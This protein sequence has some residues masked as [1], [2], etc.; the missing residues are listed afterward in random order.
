MSRPEDKLSLTAWLDVLSAVFP[1]RGTLVVGAGNG[2]G[3]WVQWLRER[4]A[5]PVLLVEGDD[6]QYQHLRRH[7]QPEL[8]WDLRHEIVAAT[9]GPVVFYRASNLAESGLIQPEGLQAL[10]PHLTMTHVQDEVAA[11]TLDS[12]AQGTGL[13]FNWLVLD[14]MPAA[15]LLRGGEAL[16]AQA[17]V[18]LVRAA[19]NELPNL[20][21]EAGRSAAGD[22]LQASGL[23]GVQLWPQR[24]PA[25]AHLLYIRDVARQRDHIRSALDR[26]DSGDR[27]IKE[28]RAEMQRM[29]EE[30]NAAV[31][32]AHH[33]SKQQIEEK[34]KLQEAAVA[35]IVQSSDVKLKAVEK[36]LK[37]SL[38]QEISNSVSQIESYL[39]LQSYLQT[40]KIQPR[41]HG[42]AVSPDFALLVVEILEH[43]EFDAVIEFGSGA[44]TVF[45]AQALAR[46][47]L[48][49][50]G[51]ACSVQ[52][53]VE[54]LEEYRQKTLLLL[55]KA[56]LQ[57]RVKLL[58]AP[59]ASTTVA[60][61]ELYSYYEFSET[62]ALLAEKLSGI[63]KPR[64]FAI[65]DGPPETTGPLARYPAL[66]L[67]LNAVPHQEMTLL[68]DDY[69]RPSEQEVA[70]RWLAFLN[71]N[72]IEH[73]FTEYLLEKKA[74]RISF[75]S[76]KNL[77]SK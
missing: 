2:T 50:K 69:Q 19:I 36:T 72:C 70:K 59:L 74:C 42:W 54:H 43:Q 48:E 65:V 71:E 63:V 14:C 30:C 15:A 29:R 35:K 9:T 49:R 26:A 47:K 57:E 77:K 1:P 67:L 46:E 45:I 41:L 5:S 76:S 66:E 25:L 12:L 24:H 56:G 40:G 44:S 16:L 53:A 28:T 3:L 8:G 60:S 58:H 13:D 31:E 38:R 39:N 32:L 55:A 75:D 18:V 33:A 20:D 62:A 37:A 68:L 6:V 73:E 7:I 34:A 11:V 4:C 21:L 22:L 23:R 52:V 64:I 10:W 51:A 17:D 61:G 27:V